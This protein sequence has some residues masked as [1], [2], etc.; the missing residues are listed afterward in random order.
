MPKHIEAASAVL[1][2]AQPF[3]YRV[4][5]LEAA[6]DDYREPLERW[7]TLR[8][9]ARMLLERGSMNLTM[10][11]AYQLREVLQFCPSGG[12]VA[13]LYKQTWDEAV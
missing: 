2:L 4:V 6:A 9:I 5:A 3:F 10:A 8:R 7:K 1:R 13:F 12:D 11:E